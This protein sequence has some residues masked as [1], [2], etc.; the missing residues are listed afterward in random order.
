MLEILR[1][2]SLPSTLCCLTME[3]HNGYHTTCW[4]I[5]RWAITC[6]IC[7]GPGKGLPSGPKGRPSGP[8]AGGPLELESAI[9]S[10]KMCR[11]NWR[12]E[13]K[14]QKKHASVCLVFFFFF[15]NFFFIVRWLVADSIG[16]VFD[17]F[18]WCS[19]LHGCLEIGLNCS[20]KMVEIS[21]SQIKI[22]S[23]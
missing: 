2:T 23:H 18:D 4:A 6:C 13:K 3:F 1:V 10:S 7:W 16:L 11:P 22:Y 15:L 21:C 20:R 12:E 8:V 9:I 17:W 14:D 19:M 5:L